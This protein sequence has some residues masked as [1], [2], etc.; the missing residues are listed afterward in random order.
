MSLTTDQRATFAAVAD[1][2]IPGAGT[3]PSASAAGVPERLDWALTHRPD[4]ATPLAAALDRCAAAADLESALD[5][6]AGDEPHLLEA[7]TVL[8]AGAY[9]TTPAGLA[10]RPYA[11]APRNVTDEIDSYVDLLSVVAERDFEIRGV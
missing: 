2:L 7:L 4:L 11:A 5:A 6:L 10:G 8:T 9:L 1:V 3:Q